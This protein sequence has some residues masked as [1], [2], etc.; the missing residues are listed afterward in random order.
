MPSTSRQSKKTSESQKSP[1]GVSFF[2][3]QLRRPHTK[4]GVCTVQAYTRNHL[5]F[6]GCTV[7]LTIDGTLAEQL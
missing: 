3:T 4:P 5:P 1:C 7:R 2:E 6:L